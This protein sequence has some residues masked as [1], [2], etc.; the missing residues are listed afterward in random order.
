MYP[1]TDKGWDWG[2]KGT[3]EGNLSWKSQKEKQRR[4]NKNEDEEK[5]KEGIVCERKE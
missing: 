3:L 5:G 4:K 1:V 2:G